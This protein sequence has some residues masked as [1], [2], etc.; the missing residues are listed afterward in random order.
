MIEVGKASTGL[1]VSCSF[2]P[3]RNQ[4]Q[5]TR[6]YLFKIKVVLWQVKEKMIDWVRRAL[7]ILSL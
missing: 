3:R 2:G 6:D 4:F 1:N 7:E 5:I